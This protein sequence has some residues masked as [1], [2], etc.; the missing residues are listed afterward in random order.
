[1]TDSPIIDD[2]DLEQVFS[3]IGKQADE[4]IDTDTDWMK[5]GQELDVSIYRSDDPYPEWHAETNDF[6]KMF[7]AILWAKTENQSITGLSDRLKT[8]REIAEAFGFT[9][10][11]IPHGDTFARAWRKRFDSLQNTINTT[12][13]TID[14]I[15]TERGSSIGGYTGLTLE[16][17]NGRSKRTE[18][19]LLRKKTNEVMKEM[20]GVVFPELDIPRPENA[21]YDKDDLLRLMT[22]MG[23]ESEAANGG[24]D[25][26]GDKLA[27]EKDIQ[28]RDP[29]Y[30]DGMRG[31]TLLNAI[32]QLSVHAITKMVN[33]AAE[34]VLTRI[35]PYTDFP[36]PVFMAIDMT[37]VAYYGERDGLKWVT[38]TPDHKQYDWCHKFATAT[39]VGDGVH[40]V[41]GMIPVG[42]PD[43]TDNQAYP[44]NKENS[45]VVGDVV[46][47]LLSKTKH[48]VTPRCVYADREFASADTIAAFEQH[49]MRYM[50]PAPRNDRTKKWLNRNVDME[51]GIVSVEKDWVLYGPVKHGVSNER[52]TTTLIGLPGNPDDDQYGYGETADEDEDLVPEEDQVAVP[53]Y[54]NTHADDKIA[55]DRRQT[56][57]KVEQYNRRGGIET[58]YKK[59][60]EFAAW[61]TSKDFSVRLFHFGFAVLLYNAWLMVDFLVQ[62]GLDVEFRSKPRI[63]AQ[64]FIS[65]IDRQLTRL[66]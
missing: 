39:L 23:L 64:R 63:T 4:I 47:K 56:K 12:A 10:E 59:I 46:R 44:G 33:T 14:E 50:M 66:I 38:G 49:N 48:I 15:A 7:L 43:F 30:E 16:E 18:Q 53:F 22:V 41:V 11:E 58:A 8:N 21:I 36:N 3:H 13:K 55:L 60:K 52:V 57:R 65:F 34:R 42:N 26:L 40:M 61:T 9:E 25:L 45:Y 19:R 51:R 2:N 37:Y 1:M 62:A 5:L 17:T 31:E 54:T 20:V 28:P 35:K 32:H 24:A 27:E 29:F 6:A